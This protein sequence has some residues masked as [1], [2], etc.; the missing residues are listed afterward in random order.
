MTSASASAPLVPSE[1]P[2]VAAPSAD[3]FKALTKE[4]A[5]SASGEQK[6]STKVL[7]GWFEIACGAADNLVRPKKAEIVAGF[8]KDHTEAE[9]GTTF[10]WVAQLPADGSMSQ[11]R[12]S[13]PKTHDIWVTLNNTDKGWKGALSSNKP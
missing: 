5:V 3:D 12:F 6:C 7:H 13:G 1:T 10:R 4:I 9:G 8:S 11:A 2:T